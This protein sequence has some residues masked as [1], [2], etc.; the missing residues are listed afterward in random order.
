MQVRSLRR[1]EKRFRPVRRHEAMKQY[2]RAFAIF[3]RCHLGM[4]SRCNNACNNFNTSKPYRTANSIGTNP[5]IYSTWPSSPSVSRRNSVTLISL[6]V[7]HL[8]PL[9]VSDMVRRFVEALFITHTETKL[10]T[11][12]R[13]LHISEE[14]Y[15]DD[16]QFLARGV[17]CRNVVF[18]HP[19]PR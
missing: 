12:G 5:S 6:W 13:L 11:F 3:L 2:D 1:T 15:E 4:P 17:W 19:Q 9:D 10:N 8:V 16:E 14:P 18:N 7:V